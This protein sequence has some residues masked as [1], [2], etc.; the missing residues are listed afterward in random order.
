MKIGDVMYIQV[1]DTSL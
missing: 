1:H